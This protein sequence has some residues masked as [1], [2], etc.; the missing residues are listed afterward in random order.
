[1]YMGELM[2]LV[3][4]DMVEEGLIFNNL[5]TNLIKERGAFPTRLIIVL[6]GA[7]A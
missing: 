7:Y 5:N 2:R 1:M 4:E 3:L 6:F